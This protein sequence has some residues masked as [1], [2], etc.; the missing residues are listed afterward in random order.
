MEV[1]GHIHDDAVAEMV[2]MGFDAERASEALQ[3]NNYDVGRSV[4]Y[5]LVG[6]AALDEPSAGPR[7]KDQA[8]NVSGHKKLGPTMMQVAI[9]EAVPVADASGEGVP[10]GFHL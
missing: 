5:L 1:E 4:E 6:G 2:A 7:F 8:R 10:Q 9:A 3:T